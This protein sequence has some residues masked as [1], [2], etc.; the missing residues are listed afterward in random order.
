[1]NNDARDVITRLA[2]KIAAAAN[3]CREGVEQIRSVF[4]ARILCVH[5]SML[6]CCLLGVS[7]CWLV[8]C[9]LPHHV[10]KSMF[11]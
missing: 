8:D 2:A 3:H 10:A 1:M 7:V 5:E 6:G 11:H 9:I 4:S